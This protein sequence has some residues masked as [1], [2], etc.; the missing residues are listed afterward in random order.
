MNKILALE[1]M[2]NIYIDDIVQLYREGYRIE[3][4]SKRFVASQVP[5]DHEVPTIPTNHEVPTIPIDHEVPMYVY[6]AKFVC[7][8]SGNTGPVINGNYKTAI[9]I[10]NPH[11]TSVCLSKKVIVAL[12]EE[13]RGIVSNL[14]KYRLDPDDAF[15]ID[16]PDIIKILKNSGQ[17]IK[18]F[19][20]G[21]VIIESPKELDI[22]GVYTAGDKNVES[23]DVEII[24][25]KII[26]R[27]SNVTILNTG[28][29]QKPGEIDN[30]WYVIEDP[31]GG[32]TPRLANVVSNTM[33][34]PNHEWPNPLV[35]S[36]WISFN[37]NEGHG[38]TSAE[39]KDFKY[40]RS[41]E[42]PKCYNDVQLDIDIIADNRAEV[43]LNGNIIGQTNNYPT[44]SNITTSNP[45]F[46]LPGQNNNLTVVVT[47]D[48]SI[49]GFNLIGSIITY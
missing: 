4:N 28:F 29:N 1:Q 41:F 16:C 30:N 21:F 27:M 35:N 43:S 26:D 40:Q 22:I 15:E 45:A 11:K 47:N 20:K 5:I 24:N 33:Y 34:S 7:G 18:K 46:F 2:K 3:E 49:T 14:Y 23:I 6:S 13:K 39:H 31:T 42:L 17:Y 48:K 9:N 12:Q 32:A 10:H 25:P 19:I 8:R 38:M 36:Q 44:L 37:V